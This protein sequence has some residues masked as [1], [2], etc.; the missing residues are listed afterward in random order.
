M[1]ASRGHD[2][3]EQTQSLILFALWPYPL[4]KSHVFQALSADTLCFAGWYKCIFKEKVH[5]TRLLSEEDLKRQGSL[6]KLPLL[7]VH[8]LNTVQIHK[9]RNLSWPLL[10]AIHGSRVELTSQKTG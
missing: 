2:R 8:A 6:H 5:Q 10:L 3:T 4:D 9:I 1:G 7:T